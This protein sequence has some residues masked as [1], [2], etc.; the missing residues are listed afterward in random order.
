MRLRDD[1]VMELA[2]PA[3]GMLNC[4]RRARRKRLGRGARQP[5]VKTTEAGGPRGNDAGE[6]IEGRK[7]HALVGSHDH[8]LTLAPHPA[9]I[10]DLQGGNARKFVRCGPLLPALHRRRLF[11]DSGLRR[12]AALPAQ[13][14]S[15]S[16]AAARTPTRSASPSSPGAGSSSAS[17]PRSAATATS[18]R[19]SVL[20]SNLTTHLAWRPQ[21]FFADGQRIR[22]RHRH[23]I[24]NT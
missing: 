21:S 10:Q 7:R 4:A 13:P 11:A 14:P 8:A 18:P 9:G 16:R 5:S 24:P 15:P 19:T 12:E 1:G 23:L 2:D 20:P 3:L 6:Q 22:R 17:S